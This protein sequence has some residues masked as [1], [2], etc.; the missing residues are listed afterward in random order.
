MKLKN[1]TNDMFMKWYSNFSFLKFSS[2]IFICTYMPYRD[3]KSRCMYLCLSRVRVCAWFRNCETSFKNLHWGNH[4]I[5]DGAV[6]QACV[7][8]GFFYLVNHGVEK[9]LLQKVFDES[10]K[11]FSLPVEEK[12][13]SSRKEHRGYT[14]LYAEKLDLTTS[15]KG[16]LL[17]LLFSFDVN[18]RQSYSEVFWEG[19]GREAIRGEWK[20]RLTSHI[21][22]FCSN[23]DTSS[24]IAQFGVSRICLGDIFSFFNFSN[25]G[26]D[27]IVF[28]PS[29]PF[30]FL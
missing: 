8:Y 16:D 4:T 6:L 15:S 28:A 24:I 7:E 26:E 2:W 10:R 11:F 21:S 14:P 17:F 29:L 9:E 23:I 27:M 5:F 19:K 20:R 12:M 18:V 1:L 13:K 3:L 22:S 25:K 30:L